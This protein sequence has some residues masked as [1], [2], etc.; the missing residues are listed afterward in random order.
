MGHSAHYGVAATPLID[1][2]QSLR[3][4]CSFAQH[5]SPEITCYVYVLGLPFLT[6]RI[7]VNSEHDLVTVRLLSICPPDALR[8]Y[9][10]EGYLAGTTDVTDEYKSKTELDFRN[11]LIAKFAIPRAK[12]FWGDGFD[13]IPETALFPGGDRIRE[14]CDE[15][16]NN[17]RDEL[18]PGDLGEFVQLWG[19]IERSLIEN[20]RARTKRNVS[21]REAINALA[22][23]GIVDSPLAQELES[24]RKFRNLAVHTPRQTRAEDVRDMIERARASRVK[25]ERTLPSRS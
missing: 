4:A 15:I 5:N 18:Q 14:I 20:A 16:R 25:I 13:A 6:N 11:R 24:L 12:S 21:V 7:T 3:V 17:I 19:D 23:F 1:L 8:P 10:Q 2:T 9:F 22:R